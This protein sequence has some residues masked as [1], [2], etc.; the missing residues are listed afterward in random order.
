MG[1]QFILRCQECKAEQTL[2]VEHFTKLYAGMNRLGWGLIPTQHR[3][4]VLGVCPS[5]IQVKA[6]KGE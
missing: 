3:H 5:C 2:I 1:E 6:L 4:N